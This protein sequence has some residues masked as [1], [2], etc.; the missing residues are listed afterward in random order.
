[1][2]PATRNDGVYY[3]DFGLLEP[4][5]SLVT[6]TVNFS[7]A[8]SAEFLPVFDNTDF[9]NEA[10]RVHG[11]LCEDSFMDGMLDGGQ[12]SRLEMFPY[13]GVLEFNW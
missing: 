10:C 8:D 13:T 12:V 1:M 3:S 9:F 6:S 4:T 11:T 7:I 2:S 5:P